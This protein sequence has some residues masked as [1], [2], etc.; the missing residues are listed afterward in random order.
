MINNETKNSAS[1]A[2][3]PT[4]ISPSLSVG[5]CLKAVDFYKS[6]FGAI[7]TYRMESLD[8][9]LQVVKLSI[10][11]AEVWRVEASSGDDKVGFETPGRGSVRMVLTVTDPDAVFH[12]ALKAG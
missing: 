10:D 4:S 3:I 11:G 2:A 12:R 6:A 7:E 1:E 5:D 9:I 8:G